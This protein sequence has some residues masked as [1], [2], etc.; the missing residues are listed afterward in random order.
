[1]KELW[2]LTILNSFTRFRFHHKAKLTEGDAIMA[3]TM[4]SKHLSRHLRS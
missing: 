4:C 1:M 3:L 2:R